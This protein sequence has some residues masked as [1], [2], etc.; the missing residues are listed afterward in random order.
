RTSNDKELIKFGEEFAK[1][2]AKLVKNNE[3]RI[4]LELIYHQQGKKVKINHLEK[5]RISQFVGTMNVVIFAP[6]D[7]MLI[8]G[9]PQQRR[10]FMDMELGQIEPMYVYHLS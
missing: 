9:A 5:Q 10:R 1:V 4:P 8:K 7:L 2:T 3:K 6:E